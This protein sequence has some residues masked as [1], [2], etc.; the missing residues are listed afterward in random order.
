MVKKNFFG[1]KHF[2]I[3]IDSFF[4]ERT[5]GTEIANDSSNLLEKLKNFQTKSVCLVFFMQKINE[6][7][8]FCPLY[9]FTSIPL[10]SSYFTIRT[11]GNLLVVS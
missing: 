11:Y 9:F 8:I 7:P 5:D 4:Q 1:D 6:G 2:L 3:L 10:N